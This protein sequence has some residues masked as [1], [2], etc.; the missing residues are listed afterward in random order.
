M[1]LQARVKVRNNA[2][3]DET[4]LRP[5]GALK[6]HHNKGTNGLRSGALTRNARRCTVIAGLVLAL[7]VPGPCV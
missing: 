3:R 1:A 5:H 2:A 7:L 6:H 4:R